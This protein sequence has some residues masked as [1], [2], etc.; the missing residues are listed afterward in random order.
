MCCLGRHL[1][2]QKD[3]ITLSVELLART[4]STSRTSTPRTIFTRFGVVVA[5]VFQQ[6]RSRHLSFS[7]RI[8]FPVHTQSRF[9]HG[10]FET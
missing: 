10:A 7:V 3:I 9:P 1:E 4:S 6:F 8:E 2:E 5:N